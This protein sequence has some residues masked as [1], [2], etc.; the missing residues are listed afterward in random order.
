MARFDDG[1]VVRQVRQI[2]DVEYYEFLLLPPP[3]GIVLVGGSL[4]RPNSL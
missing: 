4:P 3:T 2:R 1:G